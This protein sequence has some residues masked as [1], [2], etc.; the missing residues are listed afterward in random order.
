MPVTSGGNRTRRFAKP[1]S[2]SRTSSIPRKS[3][4]YFHSSDQTI[5]LLLDMLHP[6]NRDMLQ[7]APTHCRSICSCGPRVS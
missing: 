6:V 3:F 2:A 7:P 4:R 5:R 1:K